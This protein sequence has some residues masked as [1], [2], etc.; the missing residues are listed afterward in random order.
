MAK[1][2]KEQELLLNIYHRLYDSFGHRNWWPGETKWEIIVGAI[3]T[4]NVSWKNVVQAINNLKEEGHFELHDLYNVPLG[5]LAELIRPSR[6]YNVKAKK[7]KAI[8]EHIIV[9][10]QG[11]ID[12][13]LGQPIDFL[14]QELLN[15][16]GIGPETADCILLYGSEAPSF[17]VDAYTKRIYT[18]LGIFNEDISYDGMRDYFM[19][20]LPQDIGLYNDYH[21]QI[22]AL[23][24]NICRSK[25][26]CVHCPLEE[27]GLCKSLLNR[28][29]TE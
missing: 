9:K 7:L 19:S 17:V 23:G 1:E 18:R 4:Q 8:A 6:Y 11:D 22:V 16:W 28:N 12:Y 15:I 5:T 25:P 20:H 27:L 24:H 2:Q 29:I 26:V 14:R 13:F 3:L 10:Y 21:A